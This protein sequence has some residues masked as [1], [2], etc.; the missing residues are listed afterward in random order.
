M[1]DLSLAGRRPHEF[2]QIGDGQYRLDIPGRQLRLE[3]DRLR[4]ERHELHGEL[5]VS[6][7]DSQVRTIDGVIQVGTFNLSSTTARVT[8]AKQLREQGDCE[9]DFASLLEEFCQK[10]ITAERSGSPSAP[11]HTFDRPAADR[12]VT[13]D[14]VALLLYHAMIL[15]GDGGA[16]KSWV[17]LYFASRL[18]LQGLR[19]LYVD[20]ELSGVD[21][22][23]RLERLHGPDMPVVHYLRCDRPLVDEADRIRRE[24]RRLNIDY[25]IFDSIAFAIG[26]RPEEAEAAMNYFR[27]IRQIGIGSLQLAHVTKADDGDKKPFGSSFFHNSARATWF[28]KQAGVSPDGHR[29]TVGLFNRKSN[30]GRLQPAVGFEFNFDADRTIVT[31]CNIADVR[32]LS[33]QLPTWQRISHE[34]KHGAKT[35]AELAE[36]LETPKDTI[37]KALK[38]EGRNGSLFVRILSADGVHRYGLAERRIA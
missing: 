11:L 31:P 36:E 37:T 38:R 3:V 10:V 24:V 35:I 34:L 4:R 16:G 6:C 12:I 5:T 25:A 1:D 2:V 15:F 21:H 17:A 33:G 18:S 19:V 22:R 23:E 28:V 8:R 9:V 14:G 20:W 27:A 26:G 29:L 13:V 30:L 7:A 32:D